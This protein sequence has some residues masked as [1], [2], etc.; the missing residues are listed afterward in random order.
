[1]AK[2][3]AKAQTGTSTYSI[4]RRRIDNLNDRTNK[5]ASKQLAE[6][7]SSSPNQNKVNRLNDK[8]NRLENRQMR[9]IDK[10][11]INRT[12]PIK[13]DNSG[14]GPYKMPAN[15]PMKKGGTIKKTI[16]KGGSIKKK[17]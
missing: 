4:R 13:T 6:M 17:K 12:A 5:I 1:M 8:Y 11:R 7:I 10:D 15:G 9:L 3:L 16:K 14:D 2:K